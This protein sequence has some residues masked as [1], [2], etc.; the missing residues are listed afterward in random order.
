MIVDSWYSIRQEIRQN[1]I[2][3]T[4]PQTGQTLVTTAQP[5]SYRRIELSAEEEAIILGIVKRMYE[6]EGEG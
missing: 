6:Q 1:R 3:I 4:L 2:V 5:I